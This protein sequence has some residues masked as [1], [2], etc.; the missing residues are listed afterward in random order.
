MSDAIHAL[1]YLPT[2][3]RNTDMSASALQCVSS[4]PMNKKQFMD[5]LKEEL[6]EGREL[7]LFVH[8]YNVSFKGAV[9]SA[10]QLTFDT[11][12]HPEPEQP[13]ARRTVLAFDW[14]CCK[15]LDPLLGYVKDHNKRSTNASHKLLELLEDL[16]AQV[17]VPDGG[18]WPTAQDAAMHC[19]LP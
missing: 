5:A 16:S 3:G 6:D 18:D 10:G 9:T 4:P 13:A 1:L 15:Y 7:V 19:M 12:Q 11:C 14:A 8:G 2:Q 17:S